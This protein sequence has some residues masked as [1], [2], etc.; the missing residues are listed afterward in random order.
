MILSADGIT[1]A[2][3]LEADC[4]A[5]VSGLYELDRVLVV[6]VHLVETGDSLFLA[7]A[8]VVNI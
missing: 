8:G 4:C 5:D 2:E 7:S 1:C 3:I 6:G